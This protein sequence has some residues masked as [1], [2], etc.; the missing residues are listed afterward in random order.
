[1]CM[2][3]KLCG[4]PEAEVDRVG[5]QLKVLDRM[6]KKTMEAGMRKNGYDNMTMMN[7]WIIGYLIHH[8]EDNIYQKDLEKKFKVGKSSLSGTL[9]IMEEK[10]FIERKSV[11][12][13]ARVKQVVLTDKAREYHYNMEQRRQKLEEQVT[14]GLSE[15]EIEQFRRVVKRMQGNVAEYLEQLKTEKE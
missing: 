2:Q 5:Y 9:K 4:I 12:G 7:G 15:E 10:G 13:N 3:D 14:K 6:F 1:M 8:E 11:P